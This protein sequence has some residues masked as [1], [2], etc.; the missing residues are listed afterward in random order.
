MR[1]KEN[2][3]DFAKWVLDISDDAILAPTNVIVES[4]NNKVLNTLPGDVEKIFSADSI[5]KDSDTNENYYNMPIKNLNQLIPNDLPPHVLNL[6]LMLLL[7][8]FISKK[9]LTCI[10]LSGLNKDKTVLIPKIILYNSE[11]EYFF[12]L[13]KKQFSVRLAF[14]MTVNKSQRQTLNLAAPVFS[15]G[16][17]YVSFSRVKSP[18]CLFV[19]TESDKAKNIVYLEIFN[20]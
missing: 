12:T 11:G 6:K 2:E 8:F 1:V 15:H 10:H 5:R 18:D 19:K 4:I 16:Q 3:I 9:I 14:A 7:L 13:T 17:L 20:A